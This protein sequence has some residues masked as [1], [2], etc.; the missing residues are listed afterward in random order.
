M[1]IVE[2]LKGDGAR[3]LGIVALAIFLDRAATFAVRRMRR[4]LEGSPTVTQQYSLQRAATLTQ[5]LSSVLRVVIWT[6]ALLLVLGQVGINLGP[7]IAGAGIAGVALGFGAQSLVRD[8]LS[9]FFILLEDQF[10]VGQLV[11]MRTTGGTIAGKVESLSMRVT[12]LRHFDGTLHVIPNGNIMA[13]GNRSRGWARAIVD[14]QVEP[15][16]DVD[17]VRSVLDELLEEVGADP[18]L[19]RALFS[20][21]SLLGVE[22]FG[23]YRLVFRITADTWPHRRWEVERELRKR[24]KKRFDERGIHMPSA[25]PIG[26]P[27]IR[28]DGGAR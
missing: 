3:L 24:I 25:V 17:R 5:G 13:V 12:A 7:L 1:S 18:G 20:K 27:S 22:T 19:E 6:M 4:R 10:G 15:E 21:P 28:G 2:W 9:G 26:P 14:A 23:D 8:F 11:E 16:E